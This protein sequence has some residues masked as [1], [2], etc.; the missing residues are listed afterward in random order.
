RVG[1]GRLYRSQSRLRGL[2]GVGLGIGRRGKTE[3]DGNGKALNEHDS[4]PAA[5][6]WTRKPTGKIHGSEPD[7]D[8]KQVFSGL[9]WNRPARKW[10]TPPG[11]P[12]AVHCPFPSIVMKSISTFIG[13][14]VAL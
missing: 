6:P 14:A 5:K 12:R 2:Y 9:F 13:T 10:N 8:S 11:M 4:F 3:T 1:S 7:K